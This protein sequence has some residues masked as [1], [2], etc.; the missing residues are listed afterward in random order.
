M[1]LFSHH[2]RGVRAQH[3]AVLRS[4]EDSEGIKAAFSAASFH[5]ESSISCTV[6]QVAWV[7][8]VAT[9]CNIIWFIVYIYIYLIM[10][11]DV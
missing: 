8:G 10:A 1:T 11:Y 6:P 4:G 2:F 9:W 3:P 7:A 5:N